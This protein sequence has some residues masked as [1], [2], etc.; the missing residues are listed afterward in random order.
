MGFDFI[1]TIMFF[2]IGLDL[3]NVVDVTEVTNVRFFYVEIGDKDNDGDW[4]GEVRFYSV[5]TND[6]WVE[7]IRNSEDGILTD[8]ESEE[9]TEIENIVL[10]NL[11]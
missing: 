9:W 7:E 8:Y 10:Q 2:G 4:I 5:R 1:H 3:K 6:G 11:N